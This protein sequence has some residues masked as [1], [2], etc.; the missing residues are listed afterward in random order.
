MDSA[1]AVRP[2]L[3]DPVREPPKQ[4][5]QLVVISANTQES[6]KRQK[7]NYQ[8]YLAVHHERRSDVSYTL[9]QRREHL[10]HRSFFVVGDASITDAF[11]FT[12]IPGSVSPIAMI[13][14]GQ[15][16]QWPE[17]ARDLIETDPEFRK[18]I[19][20]MDDILKGLKHPPKWTIESK[21]NVL[22]CCQEFLTSRR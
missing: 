22:F 3:F 9:S 17:M 11:P 12:K 1:E 20:T 2:D 7:E 18:D 19:V 16:S 10:P 6:L 21:S 5:P 13:F 15:G 4:A 8:E 14:S